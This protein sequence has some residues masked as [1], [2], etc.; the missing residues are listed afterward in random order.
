MRLRIGDQRGFTLIEAVIAVAL[1]LLITGALFSADLSARSSM[2]LARLN[3]EATD[4]LA[5]FLEQEKAK[6]YINIGSSTT[7]NV[8][9]SDSGTLDTSDDLTGVIVITVT[10]NVGENT[11]TIVATATWTQRY[12][13]QTL[14][15]TITLQTLVAQP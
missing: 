3:L 7:A 10:E 6:P 9:L 1:V 8:V 2:R 12:I 4:A 11:K 15:R 13:S 14:A 5:T